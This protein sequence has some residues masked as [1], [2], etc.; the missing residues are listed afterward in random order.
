MRA[1]VLSW[2]TRGDVQPMLAFALELQKLGARVRFGAP[3]S[4]AG[5][6]RT[7]GVE[8]APIGTLDEESRYRELIDAVEPERNPRKQ[9][10]LLLQRVLED[11]DRSYADSVAVAG[12][13]DMIVSHW[14]Q[15]GGGLAA[16]TLVLPWISVT[17][18]PA[19]IPGVDEGLDA[20][21]RNLN[22]LSQW[23]WGERIHDFRKAR[24][25]RAVS[26]VASS[27]YSESLNLVAM[28]PL[29]L[30]DTG[31]WSANHKA[32]G[33]FYLDEP[34]GWRPDA[35]LVRFLDENERPIVFTFGSTAGFS[36]AATAHILSETI[37]RLGL[38]AIIQAGWSETAEHEFP[39]RVLLIR[40]VPH[41]WLFPRV[42]CVVHHGG[43][44]TTAAAL[45]AGV[46]AVVVW[47][48]FD[49]PFWGNL[50]CARNL[51]PAPIARWTLTSELLAQ[52]VEA[53]CSQP[54]YREYCSRFAAS[55]EQEN[56]AAV[57]AGLAL[58][59]AS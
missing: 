51:G 19:A 3:P 27:L 34:P 1:A 5:F 12:S 42:R 39:S 24:G 17:L 56:G 18:H 49:Q 37:E 6:V 50:L 11:L 44:G 40:D 25:L 53:A 13:A 15:I 9:N 14:M 41:R 47:H 31:R 2:G 10:R 4:F 30:A 21:K 48:M 45:R 57:A 8:F 16:E 26:S 52:R 7:Y 36:P 35:E 58:G 32:V 33:F 23:M 54:C 43:A 29:L 55:I 46:P 28:S 59:A 22:T 20:R 38:P